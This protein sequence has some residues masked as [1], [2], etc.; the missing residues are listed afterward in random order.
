[1]SKNP[2]IQNAYLAGE[3]AVALQLG[4]CISYD[5][6]FFTLHRFEENSLLEK[7]EK[8]GDFKLEK[9]AWETTIGKFKDVKFSISI[10]N[11]LFFFL[12]R[13]S[14]KLT[15]LISEIYQQ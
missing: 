11:T 9:I 1:M 13:S 15:F 14:A 7:I 5:L 3:T 2:A 10:T 4:H 8:V 6:D 12:A